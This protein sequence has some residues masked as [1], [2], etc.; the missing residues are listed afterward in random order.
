VNLGRDF[1]PVP[2]QRLAYDPVLLNLT[3]QEAIGQFVGSIGLS[4]QERKQDA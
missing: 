3:A 1:L 4:G 2:A